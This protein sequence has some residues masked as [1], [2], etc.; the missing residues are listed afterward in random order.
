ME[1]IV[2]L[3]LNKFPT[4]PNTLRATPAS[5][6]ACDEIPVDLATLYHHY[7]L[8]KHG[9]APPNPDPAQFEHLQYLT[10]DREFRIRGEGLG[11]T[12]ASRRTHSSE[13]GHAFCRWFL[14]NHMNIT[15]FAHIE[16]VLRRAALPGFGNLKIERSHAGDTP[17]YFCAENVDNIFLSEAKGRHEAVSFSNKDFATW[18]NQFTRVVVKDA[19]DRPRKMKGYIVATRFATES[20]PIVTSN[21]YAEDPE[22][23]GEELLGPEEGAS[24]G[25]AVIAA[26][27]A[28]IAHKL[29]QPILADALARGYVVPSEI[30]FPAILW[31]LRTGPLAGT[32][33]V[34]GYYPPAGRDGLPLR[35][36]N[37]RIIFG[38]PDPFRLDIG[39]GTFFGVEETIFKQVVA[40]ARGGI[41]LASEIGRFEQIQPFYSAV[42]IVRDGSVVGPVDFF[43]AVQNAVF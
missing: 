5:N 10:P 21:I 4:I 42:S 40:V 36:E 43:M 28:E 3:A 33:F 22:S 27:Y 31:E 25:R 17:D 35:K 39:W 41:P 12:T 23:P 2:G 34:G 7:Y 38:S 16:H 14:H 15:Y 24:I 37:G 26:H 11:P 13:L 9:K 1:R 8:D 30:Q 18:R 20:K 29:N 19:S 6:K 32:R